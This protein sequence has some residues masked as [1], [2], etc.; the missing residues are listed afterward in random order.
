VLNDITG[1]EMTLGKYLDKHP[2]LFHPGLKKSLD[3]I[4]GYASD[5]GARHGREG[6]EP[7]FAEAQFAVTTCA[8]ACTLLT[9]TNPKGKQST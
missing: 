4:Y 9:V 2:Q 6:K 7:S 3:G 5:A 1:V 8:A